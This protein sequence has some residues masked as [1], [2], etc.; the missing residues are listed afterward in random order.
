MNDYTANLQSKLVSLQVPESVWC[1]DPHCSDTG[2]CQDRDELVLEILE[3]VVKASHTSLP[4][5]GGR[6]VG[7][8]NRGHGRPVPKWQEEVEPFRQEFMYWCDVWKRE[9]RPSTGWLHST[10]IKKK[11]QYHYAVRRAKARSDQHKRT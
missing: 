7:G 2:H 5:Y 6:W 8:N 9:G 1:V 3:C 4:S 11:A 10:Y